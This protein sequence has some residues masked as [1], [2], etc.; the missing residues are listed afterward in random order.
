MIRRFGGQLGVAITARDIAKRQLLELAV[1]VKGR[2]R[3]FLAEGVAA[4]AWPGRGFH[5]RQS[6]F[7]AAQ[8]LF[9]V[10]VLGSLRLFTRAA[11]RAASATS[12]QPP[13]QAGRGTRPHRQTG[14]SK[15]GW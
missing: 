2:L 5:R 15:A 4:R 12:W 10:N 14:R 3:L 8:I 7:R 6:D 9:G 1:H 13:G 11:W